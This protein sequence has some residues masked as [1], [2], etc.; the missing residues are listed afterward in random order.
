MTIEQVSEAIRPILTRHGAT[1]AGLF[2][3]LARGQLRKGSDI[4]I[5]AE[6]PRS[7]SLLDVVGIQL[8][9]QDALGRRV[10]LVQYDAIKPL[11]RDDILRE[12]VRVL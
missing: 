1:R 10:D 5:L 9:L 3:S 2:G 11:L 12:E 8:E 6:L 7:L 4:D